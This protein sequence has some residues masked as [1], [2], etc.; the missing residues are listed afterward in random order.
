[1]PQRASVAGDAGI[2]EIGPAAADGAGFL[3][4]GLE[5]RSEDGVASIAQAEPSSTAGVLR[6][7]DQMREAD[8]MRL[9]MT[10]LGGE[11]VGDPHLWPGAVEERDR[12]FSATRRHDRVIDRRCRAERPPC[13]R[14]V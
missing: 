4:E 2:G 6:V 7:A 13:R 12:H 3:Q 1:M 8:L 9:S 10:A 5:G 14:Q 11:P